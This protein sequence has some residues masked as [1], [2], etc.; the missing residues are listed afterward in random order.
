MAGKQRIVIEVDKDTND[1]MTEFCNK[2]GLH[3]E[4]L[5]SYLATAIEASKQED[6]NCAEPTRSK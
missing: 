6:N 4:Q 5:L 2:K 1:F 3:P